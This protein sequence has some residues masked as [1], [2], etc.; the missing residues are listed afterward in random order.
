MLLEQI[1]QDFREALKAKD[2]VKK[3]A[4]S[5]AK[6]AIQ[7]AELDKR[8]VLSDPEVMAVL[9][10]M[11]KRHKDSISEFVKGSRADLVA[12]E[13]AQLTV[14]QKYLPKQMDESEVRSLVKQAIT[15]MSATPADF[16]KVMKEVL[17]KAQGQ[18][19][20]TVVSKLVK[21]ELV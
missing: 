20:G 13:Q 21:E 18:T 10:K 4:L 6:A 19:D 15:E 8:S 3:S 11:V 12:N 16:G 5:N 9:T 14:L 2:D 1:E 7:S 17:A